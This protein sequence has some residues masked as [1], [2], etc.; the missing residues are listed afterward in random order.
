MAPAL[1]ERD[2]DRRLVRECQRG[3][4]RAFSEL[5]ERHRDR[6]YRL[7]WR[8]TSSPDDADD[9]AQEVFIRVFEAIG[10]YQAHSAFSTW[11]YRLTINVCINLRRSAHP[12]ESLP[13]ADDALISDEP[14][15]AELYESS[16]LREAVKT[17]AADLPDSLRIAFTLVSLESLTYEEAAETLEISVDAVRMRVCRARRA[18]RERLRGYLDACPQ[19][20]RAVDHDTGGESK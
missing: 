14:G 2:P 13:E 5:F 12:C 20:P 1:Q 16:E 15:P 8:L 6:V 19:G 9:A 17:A 18:L 10:S 4:R 11:I 7:A 3:D